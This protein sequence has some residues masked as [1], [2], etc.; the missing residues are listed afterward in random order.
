MSLIIAEGNLLTS[1]CNIIGHQANCQKTMGKGIALQ[2][3]EMFPEAYEA[4]CKYYPTAP[5]SKFGKASF[6]I[7]VRHKKIIT[8]LY[9]QLQY[10]KIGEPKKCYT[11]VAK[12]RSAIEFTYNELIIPMRKEGQEAKFGVPFKLGSGLAGGS[13]AEVSQMLSEVSDHYGAIIYAYRLSI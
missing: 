13:W 11:D 10:W 1:D 3:K 4:D 5:E 2:I 8:N 9:G 6:G 7:S 12:L